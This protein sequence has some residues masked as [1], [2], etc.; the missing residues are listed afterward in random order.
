MWQILSG[1]D[2]DHCAHRHQTPT[3]KSS[4]AR[5]GA[6]GAEQKG[7]GEETGGAEQERRGEEAL[8][9]EGGGEEAQS[10]DGRGEGVLFPEEQPRA[11]EG[12]WEHTLATVSTLQGNA[13][14]AIGASHP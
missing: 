11:T 5:R 14:P 7:R 8:F 2:H 13:W 1:D 12:V 3:S 9:Q 4:P 10:Q 6:G